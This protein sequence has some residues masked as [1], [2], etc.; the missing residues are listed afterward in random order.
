MNV[1]GQKFDDWVTNQINFRQ[2]SLKKGS[3]GTNTDLLYQQ[4][5][6]PWLRLT[7]SVNITSAGGN[8]IL[9]DLK[10]LGFTESQLKG[11]N[12]A[13]NFILQGG[14]LTAT[15]TNLTK[16][17]G[18]NQRYD[19]ATTG[20]FTGAYGWGGTTNR[21]FIPMPGITGA[22]VKFINN[23]ALS[24]S[25]INV[26]CF[27]KEQFA[28]IDALYMRP[29]YTLLLEFGWSMYLD[30]SGD[31]QSY[32]GFSSPALRELFKT[33]STQYDII[34]KIKSER[35]IRAGN[36]E[37][38]YG[39]ISNYKWSFNPDGSYN[40]RIDLVGIGDVI[41][42]LKVN[43]ALNVAEDVGDEAPDE[44][45]K[46]IPLIDNATRTSLNL[47]MFG[48]YQEGG[49]QKWTI[50]SRPRGVPVAATIKDFRFPPSY[51]SATKSTLTIN[52]GIFQSRQAKA[53]RIIGGA[54]RHATGNP[55]IYVKFGYLIA[56]LQQNIMLNNDDIPN[57]AFDMEFK[58][59]GK[60]ADQTFFFCPQGNL[61]SDPMTCLIPFSQ[62]TTW[63]KVKL[64][65]PEYPLTK[66]LY[67]EYENEFRYDKYNGRLSQV[68]V[69]LFFVAGVL[70]EI[71][72]DDD[73]VK[74]M[75]DF[76]NGILSG[77]NKAMGSINNLS[78][79]LNQDQTKIQFIENTPQKFDKAPTPVGTRKECTFNTFGKGSIIRNIN[80]DGSIPSNFAALVT[81]GAQA[82]GNQ[83]AGNATAFSK[84]NK[85]I[86]DRIIPV[87]KSKGDTDEE[88]DTEAEMKTKQEDKINKALEKMVEGN[89][90]W[91]RNTIF[92]DSAYDN[93]Y[94]DLEWD[95]DKNETFNNIHTQLI[96]LVTGYISQPKSSGGLGL[97]PA[98]FF[99][100]FNLSLD[101]D[102][103]SGIKLF[104]KFKVDG[105]VLP[106]MYEKDKI[107]LLVKGTDHNIDEKAWTTTLT[108]QSTPV[109]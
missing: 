107:A 47:W 22:S 6:T 74:S 77:I 28:L 94:D 63:G 43:Q 18:I 40:C 109:S 37:G 35:K 2:A 61:S 64:D 17:Q 105:K 93:T 95:T 44:N 3:G 70:D 67:D 66:I 72:A 65:Y 86:I 38:I 100:P 58:N 104:E 71:P 8:G 73:G 42:T 101:I 16:G 108:T 97:I 82:N 85:G 80:L 25:E 48:L 34:N 57:C 51:D 87:K 45:D 60:D 1:L 96:Q 29:G 50:K 39:K 89:G 30:S 55:Q 59:M 54:D 103:V 36:Y 4:S 56:W 27:S 23:G 98:P 15:S 92:V 13:K 68:L 10:G 81:I 9:K 26:K 24:K 78:V 90:W 88:S 102:G 33:G 21:G 106:P 79:R 20:K 69:N 62:S 99:L 46:E 32:D 14:A 83:T 52:K 84:Y 7:S 5:K 76:L 49:G 91:A 31:L 11:S 41:E 12:L 19:L 75:L 53:S